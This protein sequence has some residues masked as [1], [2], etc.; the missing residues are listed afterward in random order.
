MLFHPEKPEVIGI[1]DWELST[2]GHPLADLGFSCI[3][4]RSSPDE[5]GGILGLDRD[6]L[7]IPTEADYVRRY[8][9]RAVPTSPLLPFHV[10][11][12]LFRFAVIFYGIADRVKSGTAVSENAAKV[13]PLAG[14]FAKRAL[15]AIKGA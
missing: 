14:R 8:Y 6:A 10:V 5:Y 11:F 9:Q 15:E 7:G 3:P 2:L 4:W 1:L 12:A 13:G